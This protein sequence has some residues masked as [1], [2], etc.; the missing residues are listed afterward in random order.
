[1]QLKQG[2]KQKIVQFLQLMNNSSLFSPSALALLQQWK[3]ESLGSY[4]DDL[5]SDEA[6]VEASK[7]LSYLLIDIIRPAMRTEKNSDILDQICDIEE[8]FFDLLTQTL[9]THINAEAFIAQR[10]INHQKIQ[11][12][13]KKMVL[14]DACTQGMTGHL[15]DAANAVNQ[16]NLD[17]F[18]SLKGGLATFHEK[19]TVQ[20]KQVQKEL[21]VA[22]Q[23]VQH[24]TKTLLGTLGTAKTTSQ[25]MQQT[26]ESVK[27]ARQD[28]LYNAKTVTKL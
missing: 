1:M 22:D 15:Y 2:T 18:T 16:N 8:A 12:L 9:P 17:N 21:E 11:L 7:V 4:F 27:Q 23:K 3:S 25:E 20:L 13:L 28:C 26:L 24:T 14:E 6:K 5:G 10:E 19:R